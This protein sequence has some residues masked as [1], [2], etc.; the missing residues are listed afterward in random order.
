MK[1]KMMTVAFLL[2]AT[3]LAA[4][5]LVLPLAVD[6]K[7]HASFQWLGKAVSFYL[8][9]GLGENSLPVCEEEEVQLILNR[10]LIRFPFDITKATAISLARSSMA[11]RLLWGQIL[12]SDKKAS[13]LQVQLFL[14]DVKGGT[15]RQLPLIKG[16]FN[17]M[18]RIQKELF[19]HVIKELAKEMPAAALPQ[20]NMTLPEY[21]KYIKS[22]LLS[23][24]D[25]KLD[26]L[27][28]PVARTKR[29]DFIDFELAKIFLEKRELAKSESYLK[30]VAD[31]PLFKDKKQFL[32]GLV[33]FFKGDYDAALRRFIKL[34][35]QNT[36]EIPTNNNLGVI[37]LIK[38]NYPLAEKC[39]RY[40]IYLKKDGGIYAN[41]VLLKQAMG[42]NDNALQELNSALQLFPENERLLKLFASFV[43]TAENKDT[44][45][46]AFRDYVRF[47]LAE[48]KNVSGEPMLMSPFQIAALPD[49]AAPSHL[50]YVEARNLFLENDFDGALQ[51]TEEAME[52]N[53]FLPE[54]HQLLALL[55]L[56]KQQYAQAET[57]AQSALFLKETVDNYLLLTKI[58]QA[59][60]AKENL[61]KTLDRALKKFPGNEELL[62][63]VGR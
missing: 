40:A 4:K 37:F 55:F 23:D 3:G 45:Q 35:Q 16:N 1:K 56:Q 27:L 14:I 51:K 39:L 38:G 34:Q 21:E 19:T 63:L 46:N 10:N 28:A 36:Y 12:Y 43:A 50:F 11:D 62:R 26:L 47:P 7:N 49:A 41:L 30:G 48:E 60:K 25:K 9:A 31:T 5:T 52:G 59:E 61:R 29:S 58:Y 20:L 32:L 33:D 24:G 42:R 22:L 8:I 57:A 53:P 13:Q 44:L 2:L 17:D 18:F 6:S 54:N 15:Q